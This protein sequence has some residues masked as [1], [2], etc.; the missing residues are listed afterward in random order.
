VTSDVRCLAGARQV[1]GEQITIEASGVVE[2]VST[3][4]GRPDP[5]VLF[6]S[7]GLDADVSDP[8]FA[9]LVEIATGW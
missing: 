3:A 9:R 2:T 7:G 1:C 4:V 8:V 6:S 5:D